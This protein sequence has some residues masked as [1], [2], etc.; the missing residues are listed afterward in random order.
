MQIE[1][2][3]KLGFLITFAVMIVT[4][5]VPF[6]TARWAHLLQVQLR[7]AQRWIEYVNQTL[8]AVQDAET[9][10]H[11]FIITGRKDFLEPYHGAL[12]RLRQTHEDLHT[13]AQGH[14]D[15]AVARWH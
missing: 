15:N 2:R 11:G 13:D 14:T 5:V 9:G 1:A 6:S 10:R 3:L 8:V 4:A 12:V 7:G